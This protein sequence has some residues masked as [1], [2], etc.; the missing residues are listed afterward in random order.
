MTGLGVRMK[1]NYEDRQRYYLTRRLPVD[2][3][4]H[5]TAHYV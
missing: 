4:I 3:L 2:P 1:Q 5:P